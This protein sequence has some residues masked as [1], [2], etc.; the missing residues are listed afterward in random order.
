MIQAIWP[1]YARL[2]NSIPVGQG[3][4]SRDF[5][6]FFL[7]WLMQL[8]FIFIHPSKLAWLFNAKAALVPIVCVGTL[9][10]VRIF[11]GSFLYC[12]YKAST[13]MALSLARIVSQGRC[14]AMVFRPL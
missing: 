13:V 5:L 11:C 14:I 3:A 1:S 7:F 8:P 2:P 10:W 4:T 6:S 9:I 12:S